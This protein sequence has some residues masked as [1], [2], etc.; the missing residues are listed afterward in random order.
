MRMV[1]STADAPFPMPV[2]V[3]VSTMLLLP[4]CLLLFLGVKAWVIPQ[5][6]RERE[7]KMGEAAALAKA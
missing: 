2:A 1:S 7:M 4:G 6:I 3:S 5:P